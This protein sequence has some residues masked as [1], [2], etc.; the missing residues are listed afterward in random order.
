M[1]WFSR[2]A[3]PT[4]VVIVILVF[5]ALAA[6]GPPQGGEQPANPAPLRSAST[7]LSIPGFWELRT[8]DVQKELQ[9]TDEQKEKLRE[10]GQKY[11]EQTRKDWAGLREMS[12]AERKKAYAEIRNKNEKRMREIR[13]QVEQVLSPEQ[14]GLLRQVHLRT[15]GAAA[16]ANP[17]ILDQLEVT[18]EQKEKLRQIREQTQEKIRQLQREMLEKTLEVLSPQQRKKLEELTTEGYAVYGGAQAGASTQK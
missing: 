17:K 2:L 12:A 11:Y 16:L 14:L 8:E 18:D 13:K 10:I 6:T 4:L 9:L 1:S 3:V 15:R 7:Y 5:S